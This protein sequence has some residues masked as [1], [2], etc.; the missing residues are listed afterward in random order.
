MKDPLPLS[1]V[2]PLKW[3]KDVERDELTSYLRRLADRVGEVVVV[4]GSEPETFDL[5]ARTWEGFVRHIPPDPAFRVANG[6]AANATTGVH[7]ASNEKVVI[8]DDDVRYTVVALERVVGLL[9]A[10]EMVRPQN[11]FRPPLPWHALWDSARSC[12]NRS[13]GADY[14]GT[15]AVRRSLFVGM[16]GYDGNV[17]FENLEL[18]RTV[19]A[20]GGRIEAPLDLYVERIAPTTE[21]FL[22]QR[23]RQ[24]YDEFALP[25]R[26]TTWL[27]VLP[28]LAWA[29]RRRTPRPVAAAALF[30]VAVAETG[31]RKA[32]GTRVFPAAASLF[33]PAW[34]LER[35]VCAWLAVLRRLRG[36]V[37]YGENT[38][39]KAA[40]RRT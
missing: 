27:S 38:I 4:D 40:N 28:F 15:L 6:K 32:G 37:R 21:R 11:Y 19:E 3:S 1:Y 17:L 35:G 20:N 25:L 2:L 7:A 36:G 39:T 13:Y 14:P 18:M 22:S 29:A 33:A 10:A 12:I 9:D 16:G 5:N 23:V 26:M 31:R 8:A 30:T 34:V 24:A